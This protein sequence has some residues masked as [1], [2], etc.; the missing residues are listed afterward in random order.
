MMAGHCEAFKEA[1][2]VRNVRSYSQGICLTHGCLAGMV[3]P[4]DCVLESTKI[5]LSS[6]RGSES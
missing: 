4:F 3:D 1:F 5:A 2:K 6:E